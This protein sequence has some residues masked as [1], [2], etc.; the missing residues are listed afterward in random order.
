M[1]KIK[2]GRVETRAEDAATRR[3][4]QSCKCAIDNYVAAFGW[5][6]PAVAQA[7]RFA[8]APGTGDGCGAEVPRAWG[9]T[10]G[11]LALGNW[12][13]ALGWLAGG[14]QENNPPRRGGTLHRDGALAGG[15]LRSAGRMA[16]AVAAAFT[17]QGRQSEFLHPVAHLAKAEPDFAG[18]LLLD[19]AVFFQG[20]Q[21]G[22]ALHFLDP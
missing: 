20:L 6:P 14:A 17:D 9:L 13:A 21:D 10:F 22:V 5:G 7:G 12:G 16:A 2:Q 19:P 18:G 3:E 8:A 4:L 15:R 1:K 11:W